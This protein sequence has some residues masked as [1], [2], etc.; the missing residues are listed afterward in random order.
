MYSIT[1]SGKEI[2][3]VI[4]RHVWLQDEKTKA[5]TLSSKSTVQ[6]TLNDP[7]S[8]FSPAGAR[9]GNKCRDMVYWVE[10]AMRSS[11]MR[12]IMTYRRYRGSQTTKSS[13]RISMEM[14]RERRTRP[15]RAWRKCHEKGFGTKEKTKSAACPSARASGAVRWGGP[16]GKNRRYPLEV[17]S[18][19]IPGERRD[20]KRRRNWGSETMRRKEEQAAEARTRSTAA[21][22]RRKMYSQISSG[23]K[24]GCAAGP[25]AARRRAEVDAGCGRGRRALAARGRADV[26]ASIALSAR[27]G[28]RRRTLEDRRGADDVD[29]IAPSAGCGRG[30]RALA[31]RGRADVDA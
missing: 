21:S 15:S 3:L 22:R 4:P 8:S 5:M 2:V 13:N 27:R 20:R 26:D 16:A 25:L 11:G 9:T 18:P 12:G 23:R 28:G 31:V 7:S 24:T 17:M 30:R 29:A 1:P 19:R 14:S 6:I 10:A